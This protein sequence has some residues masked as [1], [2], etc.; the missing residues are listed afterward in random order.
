[1]RYV[2]K[3]TATKIDFVFVKLRVGQQTE[4]KQSFLCQDESLNPD[5][6]CWE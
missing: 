2:L 3:H 4:V 6:W 1:M 5:F